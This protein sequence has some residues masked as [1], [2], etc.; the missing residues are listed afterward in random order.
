MSPLRSWLL[1]LGGVLVSGGCSA[2]VSAAGAESSPPAETGAVSERPI[3]RPIERVE[4]SEARVDPREGAL[5]PAFDTVVAGTLRRLRE[6]TGGRAHGGNVNVAISVRELGPRPVELVRRHA[7]RLQRPA[8]NMKLVTTAAALVLL[9]PGQEFRTPFESDALLSEGLLQGELVARASGDP[10]WHPE[11]FSAERLRDVA[12]QLRDAGVRR[13]AGALVLD[14]GRFLD[15]GPGPGWPDPSQYWS[16]YCALCGGFSVQGGVLWAE[17]TPGAVGTPARVS[18]RPSPHGLRPRYGVQ[19]TRG[20]PL[21]VRVGATETAVTVKGSLPAGREPFVA[22]FAHP[23][24]VDYFASV[25]AGELARAGIQVEGGVVRRRGVELD[26]ERTRTLAELR[27]SVDELYR[28]INSD[29]D[30][31]VAD[32]LFLALGH[33]LTGEGSRKGGR[34]AVTLALERLG[35]SAHGLEQV[36]GSGLSRDDRISPRQVTALLEAVLAGDSRELL[37]DSLAVAGESGTLK[38]R[39]KEEP[40]RGRVF[41][42]TGWIA[43]T[44]ALSGVCLSLDGRTLVFSILVDYPPA[45]GGLNTRGFKPMQDELCRLLVTTPVPFPD[46]GAAGDEKGALFQPEPR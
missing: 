35:V 14:E 42:K 5:E 10:V 34:E 6:L 1:L 44:S 43:G 7:D 2:E 33:T 28:P 36:D 41:A 9:G 23:D 17:V 8:S 26:P 3:E 39:M 27:S 15:P 20:G 46:G 37:L 25:L 21:D 45:L 11:G 24:P 18:V 38:E 32:Q 40:T 16:D 4:V 13:I 31:S 30:N 22:T 29:S 12:A 19:T